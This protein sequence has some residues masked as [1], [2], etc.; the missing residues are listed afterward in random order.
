MHNCVLCPDG[1]FQVI[2]IVR[3]NVRVLCESLLAV[4]RGRGTS[5]LMD[6]GSSTVA[7]QSV[8]DLKLY[9]MFQR[10]FSR[11]LWN[12]GQ[13]LIDC[14]A[15]HQRFFFHAVDLLS[16]CYTSTF[17]TITVTNRTHMELEFRLLL[18]PS[19]VDGT[20]APSTTE[21]ASNS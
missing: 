11:M 18:A 13:G 17:A 6:A 12:A 7:V 1:I 4:A 5:L 19:V 15:C 2:E 21:G 9:R 16:A 20:Q 3:K 8:D 10:V 14:L